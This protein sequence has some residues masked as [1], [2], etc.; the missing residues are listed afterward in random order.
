MISI[1]DLGKSHGAQVLFNGFSL[2]LGMGHR[3][4]VVGA[5]GS[6]K[7]TI[8]RILA[9]EEEASA[10]EMNVPKKARI[11]WLK[12]DQYAYDEVS[13]LNVVMMG[14]EEL[15]A[16]IVEKDALLANAHLE[17]DGDRYAELED[18]VMRHDGY[19]AE[20]RAAEILEGLNIPESKHREPM[21]VL[22]GG[23]KLR[24][25]LAQVLAGDPD[26]LLL[27]EPT[28]HLDILSIRWLEKFLTSYRGCAMVVSH[29]RKFLNGVCTH[30]LDVDYEVVTLYRG[31]YDTFEV[32]KAEERGRREGENDKREQ[33][34]AHHKKFI[35]KFKAKA[36]KARQANSKAKRMAK[37][38]IE[39]LAQSSRRYP[40]FKFEQC[41][42]S[43]KEVLSV[44]HVR[45]AYDELVVLDDVSMTIDRGDRVAVI[46]PNGI[47]KSTLLKI[48]LGIIDAD[49]GEVEWGYETHPGYFSQDHEDLR[50]GEND[51]VLSWLWDFKSE[52]GAGWVRGRLA[53]VLFDQHDVEKKVRHLSGGE[54]SRLVFAKL[55][56]TQPNV[57]VLDEPTNHLDM[58][59]IEALADG[60]KRYDGTMVFVSHNRW[61]VRQVATRILEIRPDGLHDYRGTYD[62][63]LQHCGDDHLE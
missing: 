3:Y 30:I 60:L 17:F 36:S 51:T 6:G 33:E 13:I 28:N 2:Q 47:G 1:N 62:E 11:G 34:I 56:V 18:I 55:G 9:G 59:G 40:N 7:S 29:D 46:G 5:N 53:E 24:V 14:N 12:Q 44:K 61:F 31:D 57:M 42:A 41:R 35:D 16:A 32:M 54:S 43:G 23:F 19:A 27:D 48:A 37:I 58:E 15:Y 63:Y 10:G 50:A 38:V 8:L 20:S 39:T 21:S 25:L 49:D 22:S 26:V 52:Q 4:G 45:K